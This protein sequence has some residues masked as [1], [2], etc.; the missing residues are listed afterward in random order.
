MGTDRRERHKFVRLLVDRVVQDAKKKHLI[1]PCSV[2][3]ET[4]LA[5]LW[6]GQDRRSPTAYRPRWKRR[7]PRVCDRHEPVTGLWASGSIWHGRTWE[8]H[9][10]RC[11]HP[12]IQ[13]RAP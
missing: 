2:P 4:G 7:A 12:E 1:E 8:R 11:N 6:P 5:I 9:R 3:N 13:H 10:G